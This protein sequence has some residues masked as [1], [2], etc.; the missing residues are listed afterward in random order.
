MSKGATER[1]NT[2]DIN[3]LA[4][5]FDRAQSLP[6]GPEQAAALDEIKSFQRRLATIF[7]SM[8]TRE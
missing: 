6:H 5:L 8:S 4:E 2:A 1:P 3:L 7:S